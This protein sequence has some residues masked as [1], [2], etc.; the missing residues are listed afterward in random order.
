MRIKQLID[1]KFATYI[2]GLLIMAAGSDLFLTAALGVMPSCTLALLLTGIFPHMPGGY[3]AFSFLVNFGFLIGEVC[4]EQKP[5]KR[6]IVQFV[7]IILYSLFIH[8]ISIPLQGINVVGM[9]ERLVF[10]ILACVILAVGIS[11]TVSSGLAVLPVEG[12]VLSIAQK[13]GRLFGTVRVYVEVLT[14]ILSALLSLIFLHN[15]SVIGIGTL[16]AAVCTGN[17][18]NWFT[19]NV[20]QKKTV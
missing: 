11:F 9:G 4:V 14:T 13:S 8:L 15:L 7:L 19:C 5:E 12:F 3:A 16:I 10:S 17:I 6:Y 20:L 2:L 18:T 1:N